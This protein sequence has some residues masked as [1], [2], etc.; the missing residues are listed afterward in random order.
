MTQSEI[1]L[2]LSTILPAAQLAYNRLTMP[3]GELVLPAGYSYVE[4]ILAAPKDAAA[5]MAL[6]PVG[7][8]KMVGAM[9]KDSSI[10]GSVLWQA[11]TNTALVA[12]R[13]T[14]NW[15]DWVADLEAILD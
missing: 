10:F 7:S 12:F 9:L 1:D 2:I 15:Q 6:A 4:D 8:Q 13:G 14:A 3:S 5:A 11:S